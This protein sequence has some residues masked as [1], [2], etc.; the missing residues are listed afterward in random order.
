M[1]LPSTPI[2][3]TAAAYQKLQDEQVR[4]NI[5]R[6]AIMKRVQ[7]ARE[8]GDLSENG[9]Y[10]YGRMELADTNRRLREVNQLVQAGQVVVAAKHSVTVQFGSTV[11]LLQGKKEVSYVLVSLHESDP[12]HGKLSMESPIG[13]AILGKKVGEIIDVEIPT[14][15]ISCTILK[16]E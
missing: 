3:F 2:P 15:K 13:S 16:I 12:L 9:A 8:M 11:T 6:E 5:D 10:K 1:P 7:V 4:L 14:G